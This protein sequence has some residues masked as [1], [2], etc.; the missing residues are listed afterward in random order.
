MN[1]RANSAV[2]GSYIPVGDEHALHFLRTITEVCDAGVACS[3]CADEPD[4]V[5]PVQFVVSIGLELPNATGLTPTEVRAR[6]EAG[7]VQAMRTDVIPRLM[8][9]FDKEHA[10]VL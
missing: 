7:L 9:A 8:R 2:P 5:T 6:V 4:G 3:V 1:D 10:R